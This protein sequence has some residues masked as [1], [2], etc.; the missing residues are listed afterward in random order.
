MAQEQS[1]SISVRKDFVETPD[2]EYEFLENF[3]A[4]V[5]FPTRKVIRNGKTFLEAGKP[6]VNF[7]VTG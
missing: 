5:A 1:K 4:K 3:N 6:K 2:L 7:D